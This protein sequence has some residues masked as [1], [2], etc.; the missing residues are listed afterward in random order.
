[1]SAKAKRDLTIRCNELNGIIHSRNLY[2]VTPNGNRRV[3]DAHFEIRYGGEP[4]LVVRDL[5]N[6]KLIPVE[7][8]KFIDGYGQEVIP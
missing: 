8:N 3:I 5:F 4:E 7:G 6:E 1:M 2:V